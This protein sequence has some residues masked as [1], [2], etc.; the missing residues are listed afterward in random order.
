MLYQAGNDPELG[1]WLNQ[2]ADNPNPFIRKLI[3]TARLGN[4]GE[5][6]SLQPLLRR[7]R[8][9]EPEP[10]SSIK[11]LST[12][13]YKVVFNEHKELD[14]LEIAFAY[15]NHAIFDDSINPE[16]KIRYATLIE[17]K[18]EPASPIGLLAEPGDLVTHPWP[19]RFTIDVPHIFITEKLRDVAPVN[20]WVLLHEM[21]HFKVPN[22]EPEFI[23]VVKQALDATNWR[24]LL[25]GY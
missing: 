19:G 11:T 18:Q 9:C 24:V 22:H 4:P 12:D 10:G 1:A 6:T 21:C 15:F 17:N 16:T 14:K 23:E 8:A 7:F 25:G 3:E 2:N 5:Y 13:A 20:Q